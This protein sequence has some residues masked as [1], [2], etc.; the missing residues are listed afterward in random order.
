MFDVSRYPEVK[1]SAE[2]MLATLLPFVLV[3]CIVF[4]NDAN[5]Y[6]NETIVMSEQEN[7]GYLVTAIICFVFI[8]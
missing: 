6:D 3:Q 4:A 8:M 2:Q 7:N 1:D 5:R